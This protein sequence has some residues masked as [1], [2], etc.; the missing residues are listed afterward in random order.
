MRKKR[1]L[2]HIVALIA[3]L[4]IVW[5]PS[6]TVAA[7]A[8]EI[9]GIG[10]TRERVRRGDTFDIVVNVPASYNIADT[11]EIRVKFDTS[12]FE[13]KSWRPTINNSD[14]MSNYSNTEGF[15]VL[16]AA[17]CNASLS[18]GLT[19]TATMKVKSNAPL[20]T[21][22]FTLAKYILRNYDTNYR[23][24]PQTKAVDV[25]ISNDITSVS[26]NVSLSSVKPITSATAV[27]SG[28]DGY[29]A[30]KEVADL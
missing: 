9:D 16:V 1:I 29:L 30:A 24:A 28:T 18:N 15:F 20:G 8:T 27:L 7:G 10:A 19:F 11:A 22:T 4:C 2:P 12:V 13:V 25:T 5:L 26:G 21:Y 3:A 6:M 23:W 17:N 14:V